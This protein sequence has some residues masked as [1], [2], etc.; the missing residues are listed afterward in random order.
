MEKAARLSDDRVYRYTL[1]RRWDPWGPAL[2]WVMLN[3]SVADASDDDPT[4]RRVMGFSKAA[5]YAACVVANL[6]ALISTDPTWL[7]THPHPI[8]MENDYVLQGI[9]QGAQADGY[10]HGKEAIVVVAWGAKAP[11]DRVA[12]VVHQ[13]LA[14]VKLMCL[15]TT[16]HGHPR[17][18]LYVPSSQALEPWRR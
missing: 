8:G 18:P 14:G 7:V 3:P 2:R 13:H 11:P 16:K 1:M 6:F 10:Q 17:H 4:I 9:A 15:G 5:G 12:S